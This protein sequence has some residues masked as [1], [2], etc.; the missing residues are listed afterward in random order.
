ML[1]LPLPFP[2]DLWAKSQMSTWTLKERERERER[3]T[4]STKLLSVRSFQ[5][6]LVSITG[7]VESNPSDQRVVVCL[8]FSLPPLF[9]WCES[10]FIFILHLHSCVSL[11]RFTSMKRG[12]LDSNH[13]VHRMMACTVVAIEETHE[14]GQ[15]TF[16]TQGLHLGPASAHWASECSGR[17]KKENKRRATC[18]STYPPDVNSFLFIVWEVKWDLDKILGMNDNH[19]HSDT[20]GGLFV[21]RRVSL[22]SGFNESYN[23][24]RC[25]FE[26]CHSC[27]QE[28]NGQMKV[29]LSLEL[30]DRRHARN[31]MNKWPGGD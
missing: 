24:Q 3:E 14:F 10:D 18:N 26:L 30:M 15:C 13:L 7:R 1:H 8:S 27:W 23:W 9:R 28:N 17:G 5:S 25:V 4:D 12:P 21:R 22:R 31:S 11:D 6:E 20:E 19:T 2:S 29:R 16:R